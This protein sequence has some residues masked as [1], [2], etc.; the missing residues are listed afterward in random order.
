MPKKTKIFYI[1][2]CKPNKKHH[3]LIESPEKHKK[4]LIAV[5]KYCKTKSE[6]SNQFGNKNF[7]NKKM[8]IHRQRAGEAMANR[9]KKQKTASN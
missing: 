5:C 8:L 4:K 2:N 6:Y 1:S 9:Y 7:N 3:W